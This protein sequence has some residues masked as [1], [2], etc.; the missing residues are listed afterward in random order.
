VLI[1]PHSRY[2]NFIASTAFLHLHRRRSLTLQSRQ[3]AGHILSI[4]A[5]MVEIFVLVRYGFWWRL[6]ITEGRCRRGDIGRRGGNELGGSGNEGL[7]R[8]FIVDIIEL[9]R[10]DR[11]SIDSKRN[12]GERKDGNV[13][14]GKLR[15]KRRRGVGFLDIQYQA[16]QLKTN[17]QNFNIHCRDH[18][19]INGVR[20]NAA[21]EPCLPT[22][23]LD[24]RL[25]TAPRT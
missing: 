18:R 22:L 25:L 19:S 10:R 21:K 17:Y 24:D 13:E 23:L 5:G 16:F 20:S 8:M 3:F 1:L 7:E 11:A 2:S 9:E 12:R 15:R 6:R 4:G 14:T